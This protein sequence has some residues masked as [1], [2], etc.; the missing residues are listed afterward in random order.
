MPNPEWDNYDGDVQRRAVRRARVLRAVAAVLV[1]GFTSLTER[2][3][4]ARDEVGIGSPQMTV[5]EAERALAR[6]L[7]LS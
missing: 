3:E 1:D 6:A 4:L 5:Q 7:E 2:R